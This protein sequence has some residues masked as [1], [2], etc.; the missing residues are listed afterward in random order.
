M[1]IETALILC[2]QCG[3]EFEADFIMH[4]EELQSLRADNA[5]LRAEVD[6]L[7]KIGVNDSRFID[8]LRLEL[9]NL[10]ADNAELRAAVDATYFIQ[11][12]NERLTVELEFQRPDFEEQ[13][14]IAKKEADIA[15]AGFDSAVIVNDSLR[16]ENAELRARV[17]ACCAEL[18]ADAEGR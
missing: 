6:L 2:P 9:I 11:A 7:T 14:A 18:M 1:N 13:L 12:E 8:K 3:R 17:D 15:I 10:R 5:D 4:T 16:A